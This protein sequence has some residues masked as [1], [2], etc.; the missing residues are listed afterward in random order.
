MSGL[1]LYGNRVTLSL[2]NRQEAYISASSLLDIR[3]MNM[4]ASGCEMTDDL[5]PRAASA[6]GRNT[7]LH[8]FQRYEN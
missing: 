5:F 8:G 6:A 4:Y 3:T 7:A 1:V 2:V